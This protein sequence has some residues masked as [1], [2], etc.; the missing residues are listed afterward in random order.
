MVYLYL[1]CYS[2]QQ[3]KAL[4]FYLYNYENEKY[5]FFLKVYRSK[6]NFQIIQLFFNLEKL[7]TQKHAF[8]NHYLKIKSNDVL[9]G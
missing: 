9:K 2:I 7:I 8:T 3:T 5:K 1:C 4:Q 6:L